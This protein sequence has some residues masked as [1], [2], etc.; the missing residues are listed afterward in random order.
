LVLTLV[1]LTVSTTCVSASVR[2]LRLV[3]DAWSLDPGELAK[4][5]VARGPLWPSLRAELLAETAASWERELI[6]GLEAAGPARVPLVN[7][8]LAELDYQAQRWSRVPRVCASISASSGLLL[9]LVAMA[10]VLS[11]N[12]GDLG[13]AAFNA[14]DVI[15]V[16]LAGA[17]FCIAAQMRAEAMVREGLSSTDMLVQRLDRLLRAD[18]AGRRDGRDGGVEG[19]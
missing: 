15:A 19:A 6:D 8:H 10:G 13:A 9:A 16:G 7:A 14:I 5:A 18:G 3:A 11:S 2:R 4:A 12:E 17:A 1:A